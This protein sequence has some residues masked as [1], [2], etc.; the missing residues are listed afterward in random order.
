[1]QNGA[2]LNYSLSEN[3]DWPAKRS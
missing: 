1:M 3:C 2:D